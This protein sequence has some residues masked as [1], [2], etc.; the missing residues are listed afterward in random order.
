MGSLKSNIDTKKLI[1]TV[2]IM[3]F[4]FTACYGYIKAKSREFDGP[5]QEEILKTWPDLD[6]IKILEPERYDEFYSAIRD[7]YLIKDKAAK[8]SAIMKNVLSLRKWFD[9]HLPEILNY[10][11]DDAVNYFTKYRSK[12][13]NGLLTMDP[14]GMECFKSLYPSVLGEPDLDRIGKSLGDEMRQESYMEGFINSIKQPVKVD[15]LPASQVEEALTN[16]YIKLIERHGDLVTSEDINELA[17]NPKLSCEIQRDFYELI[18]KED[19][20]LSAEITRYLNG[21]K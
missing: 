7:S 21:S 4:I 15:R 19:S 14:T 20:H 2:V 10:S 1:I 16:I 6:V 5:T 18:S 17:K 12:L 3:L 13:F 8:N 9:S 11:A